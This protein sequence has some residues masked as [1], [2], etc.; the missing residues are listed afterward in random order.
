MDRT[1]WT[2]GPDL[3]TWGPADLRTLFCLVFDL[4]S[5]AEADMSSRLFLGVVALAGVA[6]GSPLVSAQS[7]GIQ[8]NSGAEPCARAP[9]CAWSQDRNTISHETRTP[10]SGVTYS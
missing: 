8:G 4:E 7:G 6:L 9:H 1:L 5:R 2:Y 3:W 10:D